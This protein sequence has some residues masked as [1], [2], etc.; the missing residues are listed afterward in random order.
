MINQYDF[1]GYYIQQMQSYTSSSSP[2]MDDY[3]YDPEM[4]VPKEILPFYSSF[5]HT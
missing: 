5:Y 1:E 4:N 2:S 3:S